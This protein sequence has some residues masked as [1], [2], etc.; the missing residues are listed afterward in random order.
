MSERQVHTQQQRENPEPEEGR[1]PMPWFVILL[2]ALLFAFGV[3]YIASTTLNNAPTWGD[4]RTVVD[5]QGPTSAAAGAT[6]DGAA[7]F[8]T[9]CAACHQANGQGL[10][11][12]FPPLAGSEWVAGKQQ[13]LAAIVLHGVN[14]K[15]TVN[16]NMYNGTMPAFKDQLHDAEIAAVL[17]HIRSA[18]GRQAEAVTAD[19]VAQARKNT[20]AQAEPYNG[21]IGLAALK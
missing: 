4:S 20:E 13:A 2:T 7:V 17:T 18:W 10:P 1:N 3:V 21:D 12:V 6:V 14:G 11:G 5:L 19:A 16:G 15:L 8:S 9:R